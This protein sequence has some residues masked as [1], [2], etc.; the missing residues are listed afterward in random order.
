MKSDFFKNLDMSEIEYAGCKELFKKPWE[1]RKLIEKI[2][3]NKTSEAT[4]NLL[5]DRLAKIITGHVNQDPIFLL[6]IVQSMTDALFG[7]EKITGLIHEVVDSQK[8]EK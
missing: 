4:I 7:E 1:D 2:T 8:L 5:T 3:D 6:G